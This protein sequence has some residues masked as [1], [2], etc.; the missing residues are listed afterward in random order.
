[1]GA[2]L[3]ARAVW[4]NDAKEWGLLCLPHNAQW[5]LMHKVAVQRIPGWYSTLAQT[6]I[7][8]TYLQLL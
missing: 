6:K 5:W 1:M 8:K 3:G 2:S 7:K 4:S